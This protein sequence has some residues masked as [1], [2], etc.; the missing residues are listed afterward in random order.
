MNS[1]FVNEI[2]CN[3]LIIC[4]SRYLLVSVGVKDEGAMV[5]SGE[6]SQAT[7]HRSCHFLFSLLIE[8]ERNLLPFT[9]L[10]QLMSSMDRAGK[11]DITMLA[12][13]QFR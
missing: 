2:S 8:K 7:P 4:F 6:V 5:I 11:T 9:L 1:T 3:L 12:F 13:S 10:S